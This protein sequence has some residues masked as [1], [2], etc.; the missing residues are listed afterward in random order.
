MT[1]SGHAPGSREYRRLIVG[2]FFAVSIATFAQLYSARPS[3]RRSRPTLSV[4]PATA[5]LSVSA[6]TLGL[7]LAVIPWS[8][9]AD[10]IGRVPGDGHGRSHGD[11]DWGSPRR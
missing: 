3:C 10:R 7:A 11:G 8:V 1:F 2:L 9:V 4:S 6:A 5:A